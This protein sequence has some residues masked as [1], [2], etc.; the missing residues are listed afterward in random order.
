M[1]QFT[2]DRRTFLKATAASLVTTGST[3][4]MAQAAGATIGIVYVGPRDDFG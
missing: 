2:F 3:A 4:R 1:S